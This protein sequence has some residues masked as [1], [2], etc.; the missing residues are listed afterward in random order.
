MTFRKLYAV[1]GLVGII[2]LSWLYYSFNP[3]AYSFFPQCPFYKF[4]GF[5]CP[6]CGSQRAIYCVLH[7]Q[8]LKAIHL[9][10]L[11]VISMPFL[12]I[13]F[14]Y[15]LR[16]VIEKKDIRW[17]VLYHPLTPKIIFVV[18]ISFWIL[19]NLPQYPF[20]LFKA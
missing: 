17:N 6:G 13:H 15:K 10:L 11:L 20:L 14:G 3:Q 16:S 18:V 19:R 8:I 12:L 7:G 4:T 2:S 1:L 9:N 5:D